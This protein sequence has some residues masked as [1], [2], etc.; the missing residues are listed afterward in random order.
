MTE[1]TKQILI[2][3]FGRVRE[4]V[5]DLTDGL[6]DEIATY[7]PDPEANSIAWLLWHL[8]RIQDDHVAD[9]AL[10][11]QAWAE[12]R[13]RFGLPF[14]TW[15]TGYGHSPQDVA[16]VRASGDLLA[17]YHRAVHELTL[18]YLDG[19]TAEELDRIVD[20]RW[21]PPVTAAVRLVSVIGDTMQHLGQAAYVR[22]LAQRRDRA[23]HLGSAR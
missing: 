8:T 10:V 19:M 7:R 17:D 20:T 18:R 2:D 15:A 21:D 11:D 12:W 6:T 5:V 14:G 4:L 22:G 23:W 3:A 13:D 1:H 9:L 16:A